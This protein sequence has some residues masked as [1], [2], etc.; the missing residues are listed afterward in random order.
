M[1]GGSYC[2]TDLPPTIYGSEELE[3]CL[4]PLATGKGW[5]KE[6]MSLMVLGVEMPPKAFHL[7]V[8]TS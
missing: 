7:W 3:W 4:L 6:V 8:V 5:R 1:V 2:L